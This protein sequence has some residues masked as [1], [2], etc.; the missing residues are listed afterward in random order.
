MHMRMRTGSKGAKT[1][2]MIEITYDEHYLEL[3]AE[4]RERADALAT[5][6]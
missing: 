2:P 5:S 4:E 6:F 3:A 1:C